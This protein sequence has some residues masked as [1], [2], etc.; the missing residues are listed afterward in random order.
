MT[1]SQNTQ[2]IQWHYAVS[3]EYINTKSTDTTVE[4][5][6]FQIYLKIKDKY[7]KVQ[8]KNENLPVSYNE[9]RNKAQTLEQIHQS[10]IQQFKH[11]QLLLET[12]PIIQHPDVTLNTNKTEPFTQP[13]EYTNYAELKNTMKFSLPTMND[14]I[15]KSPELY[16]FFYSGQTE[17]NDTL[18]YEAQKQNPV[19][20]QLLLWKRYKKSHLHSFTSYSRKQKIAALLPT[21][22]R[23]K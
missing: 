6:H 11:N 20:R 23:F 16:N 21:F 22:A 18:L 10:K 1:Q 4:S 15:P 2:P 8:L 12:Y 14:F 5:P 17:L 7:F 3:K 19:I 13:T 9:F